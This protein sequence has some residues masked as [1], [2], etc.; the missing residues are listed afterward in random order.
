[1]LAQEILTLQGKKVSGEMISAVTKSACISKAFDM[2]SKPKEV[3][4]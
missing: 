1:M 3:F 4:V 2:T